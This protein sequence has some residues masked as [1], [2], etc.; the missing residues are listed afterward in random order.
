MRHTITTPVRGLDTT[1]AGVRFT[2][3][4]AAVEN[5]APSTLAYFRR[6]GYGVDVEPEPEPEPEVSEPETP[7]GPPKWSASKADWVAYATSEAAGDKR[8]TKEQA[9]DLNHD[10]LAE[11]FLGPKEA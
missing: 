2:D 7:T 11:H 4:K 3:G 1:V 5:I 6:Q 8:L 10:K 9:D